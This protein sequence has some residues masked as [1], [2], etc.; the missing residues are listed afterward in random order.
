MAN[1]HA[2]SATDAQAK[3]QSK[4]QRS[5]LATAR[6]ALRVVHADH[7]ARKIDEAEAQL[8]S[9][10]SPAKLIAPDGSVVAV[11]LACEWMHDAATEETGPGVIARIGSALPISVLLD[12]NEA[13]AIGPDIAVG[14][15][16]RVRKISSRRYALLGVEKPAARRRPCNWLK[17]WRAAMAPSLQVVGAA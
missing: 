7:L 8:A 10:V 9:S 6:A 5:K 3:R 4:L 15:H 11:V 14:D 1:R 13:E 16:I 12:H 2:A 17:H